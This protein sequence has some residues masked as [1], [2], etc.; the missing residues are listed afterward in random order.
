[1]VEN[2][3][4]SIKPELGGAE[5]LVDDGTVI[6][7]IGQ[8]GLPFAD[9]SIIDFKN[10]HRHYDM[11]FEWMGLEEFMDIQYRIYEMGILRHNDYIKK[12]PDNRDT[13]WVLLCPAK[14][15]AQTVDKAHLEEII[16]LMTSTGVVFDALVIELDK[17]GKLYDFQEGR[18]RSMALKELG[19]SKIPVWIAKKRF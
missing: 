13:L 1:M 6:W 12:H 14:Y 15:W 4:Y 5:Q 16:N 3:P 18:H 2:D 19:K 9:T 8:T 11:T 17:H 10:S 7:N